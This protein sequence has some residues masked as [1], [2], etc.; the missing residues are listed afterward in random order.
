MKNIFWLFYLAI[1]IPFILTSCKDDGGGDYADKETQKINKFVIDNMEFV[2]YWNAT[3]DNFDYR[4]EKDTYDLFDKILKASY[5]NELARNIDQWSFLTDDYQALLDYFAGVRLSMGHSIRLYR[6][7]DVNVIGFIEYVEPDSPA[8]EAELERGM[9]FYMI[10]G[11]QLTLSNYST[12]LNQDNYTM[13]F[14]VLNLDYSIT[15]IS[16]SVE[17]S[18]TTLQTNPIHISKVIEYEGKKIGYL[19]YKSFIDD[20]ND[21]LESVFADFKNQGVSD[22]VLDLRYN[23]GGAVSTAILLSSMIAPSSAIGDVFINTAYNENLD[24]YYQTRYPDEEDLFTYR[25]ESNAN[26]LDLNRLVVLTTYKTASAS[27]MVMYG[28]SPH[29]TVYQIG[30]QTHGKYYGSITINDEDVSD[31]WAMQPIVM[32]AENKNNSID[33]REGLIP[34]IDRYDFLDASDFY[35]LGDPR[36]DFLALALEYLTGVKPTGATLKS[37]ERS[38]T[39]INK[40]YK[41]S[42]PLEYD[43]RITQR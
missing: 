34:D 8:S 3:M 29:M 6:L 30:E 42:H 25:L 15:P 23:G 18:A 40:E 11:Q 16:P 12:L 17:L 10:D 1:L 13:T 32:R 4:T 19:M 38:F 36:E 43:M 31:E 7:D 24:N 14:G 9:M 28:L 20:Y 22:L 21:Q 33:Y 41:I 35:P 26:N 2:Y 5:D 27:E 39:P 37:T